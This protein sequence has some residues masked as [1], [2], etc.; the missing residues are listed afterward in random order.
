MLL[1]RT[2]SG[3]LG[4]DLDN[5]EPDSDRADVIFEACQQLGIDQQ[6]LIRS[7][8]EVG[9]SSKFYSD[10][11]EWVWAACDVL[12]YN[13]PDAQYVVQWMDL[14]YKGQVKCKFVN[15][16]N[17]C[18]D[19]ENRQDFLD[20]VADAEARR[21]R[22]EANMRYHLYVH[23]QPVDEVVPLSQVNPAASSNQ[24]AANSPLPIN[25]PAPLPIQT[26]PMAVRELCGSQLFRWLAAFIPLFFRCSSVGF[27]HSCRST[28]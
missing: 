10:H 13:P 8:N 11:G 9:A 2:P 24:M 25:N 26:S 16:L 15:R 3:W 28:M 18:F 19:D 20:R 1:S 17:L 4:A 22:A 21:R 6:T 23:S 7:T 5:A 14:D 27:W 12:A